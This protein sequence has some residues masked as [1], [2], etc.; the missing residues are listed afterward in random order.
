V[1]K[2]HANQALEVLN[3]HLRDEDFHVSAQELLRQVLVICWGAFEILVNDILRVLLNERPKMIKAFTN[4]RH[5]REMLSTRV[6]LE[7]LEAKEFNLSS[8]M[9]DLFCDVAKLDSLEKIRDAIKIYRTH[10]GPCHVRRTPKGRGRIYR[11][12]LGSRP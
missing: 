5:Y 9:G 8:T 11:I 12:E 6:L 4:N 10:F 7:V 3:Q 2:G 1:V